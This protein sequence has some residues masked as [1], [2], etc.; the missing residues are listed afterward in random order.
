MRLVPVLLLAACVST[1]EP[2]EPRPAPPATPDVAADGDV[3]RAAFN[4]TAARMALPVFMKAD[5]TVVAT[6]SSLP[7]DG[8]VEAA[9]QAVDAAAR[10]PAF[11]HGLSDEE[12]T[13][14][15]AVL[16]ELAQGRPTLLETDLSQASEAD[17]DFARKMLAAGRVLEHLH[18]LQRGVAAYGEQLPK[19]DPASRALFARNQS[20]LCELSDCSAIPGLGRIP[21]GVYPASV[22][23][24]P[25]F[26]DTL[27]EEH[28]EAMQPFMVL[29]EVDGS[30]KAM[31]LAERWPQETSQAAEAVRQAAEALDPETEAPQR[32][33]LLAVADAFLSNDW[34]A[35]DAA[36]AKVDQHN[37][38]WYVRVGPDEVYWDPCGAH[39]GFH[40]QLAR[41]DASGL[42][43]QRRF[44]PV[45]QEMEAHV[46][47]LAGAPY[48]AR[49][50]GFDLP[51]FIEVIANY[52]DARS[53]RGATVGQSLPNWGPVADAGGRTV[54]MTNIGIDADSVAAEKASMEA[55]FCPEAA[56]LWPSDPGPQLVSTILHEAGHNMGPSHEYAVDGQTDVQRFGGPLA[57]MM[58]ELKAQTLS[59]VLTRW[60]ADRDVLPQD[61]VLR[62]HMGDV[63]WA[64]GQIGNGMVDPD[65]RPRTYPQLAAVQLGRLIEEGALSWE[66]DATAANGKDTGCL[67]VHPEAFAPA[68]DALGR[69]VL[70]IKAR[71][72]VA[73]ARALQERFTTPGNDFA[74]L[75]ST[76][77]ERVGRQPVSS[78]VY[79]VVLD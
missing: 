8:D 16:D 62:A 21:V 43:W 33:Y 60:L 72:D 51:E 19:D 44:D 10:A 4:R 11:P 37:S 18:A 45:K 57:A 63:G 46:A 12:R 36:W 13:R 30:L 32:A 39:A 23:S 68:V 47:A 77:E 61:G 41:V 73:A 24:G 48:T 71:G 5:G 54:A 25:D 15:Q 27:A 42:E 74:A 20:P 6:T 40:L 65:G 78:Y 1:S 2:V 28:P 66:A 55:L 79:R 22:Q 49:E 56:A 35:A 67:Q 31:T 69:E 59:L 7:F 17:R 9:R 76:I 70:G 58:E 26:C 38:R 53:G 29:G 64:L 3:D 50:V 34:Y 52:G 75:R 14:R